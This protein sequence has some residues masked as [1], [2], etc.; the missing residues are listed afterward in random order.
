MMV[1]QSKKEY[2]N[3]INSLAEDFL[4]SEEYANQ[5][6]TEIGLDPEHTKKEGLM[7]IKKLQ[8]K[9]R[10]QDAQ[11]KLKKFKELK[12]LFV[13]SNNK[14]IDNSVKKLAEMLSDGNEL[15]YN[16]YYRKL[17]KL[18]DKDIGDISEEQEFLDFLDKMD[19]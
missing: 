19:Q 4:K 13:F 16:T 2:N 12:T 14:L 5:Y 11:N 17:E 9:K 3:L 15:S 18:S 6:L 1:N 7:F 10:I 8:K